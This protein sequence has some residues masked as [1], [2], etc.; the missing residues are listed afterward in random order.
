MKNY[1]SILFLE[2]WP[3]FWSIKLETNGLLCYNNEIIIKQTQTSFFEA[4]LE[5]CEAVF[6]SYASFTCTVDIEHSFLSIVPTDCC[7][8]LKKEES[9]WLIQPFVGGENP[10][11]DTCVH[12]CQRSGVRLGCNMGSQQPCICILCIYFLNYNPSPPQKKTR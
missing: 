12:Y 9:F 8:H 2:T 7:H 10:D 11:A 1:C 6:C 3:I 4:D 5:G